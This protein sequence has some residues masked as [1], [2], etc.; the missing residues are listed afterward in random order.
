[1]S[2]DCREPICRDN[3]LGNLRK[4]LSSFQA[5]EECPLDK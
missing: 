5:E 2:E 3:P 1:M 4:N